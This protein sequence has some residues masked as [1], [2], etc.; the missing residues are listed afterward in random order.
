MHVYVYVYSHLLV[1]EHAENSAACVEDDSEGL[2]GSADTNIH[3]VLC[4]LLVDNGDAVNLIG[5]CVCVLC[6]YAYTNVCG[7][8]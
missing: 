8:V 4:A 1:T 3:E 7:H 6:K 2:A 5:V